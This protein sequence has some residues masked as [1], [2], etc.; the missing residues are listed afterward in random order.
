MTSYYQKKYDQLPLGI[1]VLL[2]I[3]SL[4]CTVS[5]DSN[6]ITAEILLR[7][8]NNQLQ[9][10]LRQLNDWRNS[11]KPCNWTGISCD[12]HGDDNVVSI[13]LA[14][15]NISGP[16]PANFCRIPTLR[17][18]DISD[19]YFGGGVNPDSSFSLCSRLV[20]LNLSSNLFVGTL[21]EF[22]P[23]F[24]NL[25]VLDLSANNFS[26]EIPIS[27]GNLDK[28]QYLSL[29]SNLLNGS[30]PEFL[31]NLTELTR[32]ILAVNPFRPSPLPRNI[33]RLTKLEELWASYSN[34]EGEIPDSIGNLVSIKNFDVAHNNLHGKIPDA[35]GG[36]K[37]VVQIELWENQ[38][39]GEIPDTFGNLTSLLRFDASANSLTGK[40]P[41][42]LAGLALEALAI[43]DNFLEGRIPEILASNPMLVDLRLFNNSL[44]GPLPI[45]M[46][47]HS[48][49]ELFDVSTNNLEGPLPLNLCGRKKLQRL[50]ILRNRFSGRIPDSYGECDSLRY[51]RIHENELSG[52]VPPGLW[53]LSK[54]EHIELTN[55]KLEG[56]ISKSISALQGLRQLLISGNKFSGEWPAEICSLQELIKIYSNRN[57]FSG[58]LPSCINR[59]SKLQEL[60]AQGNNFS[61]AIP[62]GIGGLGQ[63]AQLDLSQNRF[64]GDIP[65]EL[66]KLPVL[67]YLNLSNNMLSGEIPVDL[68]RLRLSQFD[69]SNNRLEGRVPAGLDTNSFVS[70]LIGNVDLC[71]SNLKEISPCSEV[72]KRARKKSYLLVGVL[73]A[74]ALILIAL[75]ILLVMRTKNL[76]TFGRKRNQT[77]KVTAFQKVPLDEKDVLASLKSENVI[78]SGGSGCV[79]RVVLKSGQTVAA[80]KLWETKGPKEIEG[81]FRSEVET[82][83]QIR[84]LNI[85]KLLFSCISEDYRILVYEYME[86]GSLGDVL[87]DLE[88]GGILMDWPKR[89]AIVM[90]TAQG[91]AYLHHDCVPP[92]MHRDLKSNNILLDEEFRPKVAD[93]G[94]AKV[95]RRDVNESGQVM[96]R[97]AGSYGYIAPEYGYTMKVTAKSDIYSFGILLLELLTGKRPNDSTFDENT[98]IVKWVRDITQPSPKRG[99]GDDAS[100]SSNIASLNRILDSRMDPDTIEYQEVKKVLNVA[101]L[102]TTESPIRR[103]SMRRVIDLLKKC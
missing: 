84:H 73:P 86:N 7:V 92:I 37:N 64:S 49:L 53:G 26:G 44:S 56:T 22:S 79:Y 28:L 4:Y 32:L 16:F 41:E 59:L 80:K 5:A 23:S 13:N 48:D 77:W 10:P 8:K 29:A 14:S 19:N 95:L 99:N 33:G 100:G 6:T 74:V 30:I 2:F 91:L 102:C 46:G 60:H 96:S 81:D 83:G 31:S 90:G 20:S 15:F 47:L 3:A 58:E 9:D 71:S 24:R 94:L 63:L 50:M 87:H 69:I 17:N 70:G 21:P 52:V 27:F 97:V 12:A 18:L 65:A 66:G 38:L 1:E 36:M 35:I 39:S 67:K 34:I 62:R 25:T 45:S 54:L 11:T 93:F 78:G 68:T 55:N 72:P 89:F 101:L 76:I 103:P 98:S 57:Q 43:R 40:I 88:G 85:L 61:G 82:M 51:L 42:S 75:L